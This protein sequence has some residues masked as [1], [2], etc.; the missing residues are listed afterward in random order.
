MSSRAI[1]DAHDTF[2]SAEKVNKAV[3]HLVKTG[4]AECVGTEKP[5]SGK[6]VRVYRAI[7]PTHEPDIDAQ[8]TEALRETYQ[9]PEP[10]PMIKDELGEHADPN[11]LPESGWETIERAVARRIAE[12]DTETAEAVIESEPP[13]RYGLQFIEPDSDPRLDSDDPVI[14]EIARY[15]EPCRVQ[16]GERLAKHLFAGASVLQD[17][18][19]GLASSMREAADALREFAA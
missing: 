12:R 6:T 19:P 1:Y 15:R 2:E 9:E 11:G 5:A 8:L 3:A 4:R 16:D 10:E 14:R 18:L 7:A 13:A 17:R